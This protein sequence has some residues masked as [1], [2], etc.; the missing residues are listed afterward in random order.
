MERD[1]ER[2]KIF[3]RESFEH[4]IFANEISISQLRYIQCSLNVY[5]MYMA[6]EWI[7]IGRLSALLWPSYY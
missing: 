3:L 7:I 5:T 6:Y 2:T 1:R 4:E